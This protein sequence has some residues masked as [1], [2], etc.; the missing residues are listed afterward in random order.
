[1]Q[2]WGDIVRDYPDLV[3]ELPRDIVALEWGYEAEHPFDK[4][5]A[6]FANSKIPFYVC[7]GTS[8]WNSVAG[9][10]S[11]ALANLANAAENGLKHDAIG[12]LNTDWG[13]AGHWQPL[14]VS[15]LGYAYGAAVSW[16]VDPNRDIDI[17]TA[18]NAFS[19][20]DQAGITGQA[21]YDLGNVYQSTEFQLPNRTVLFQVLQYDPDGFRLLVC[22]DGD[23]DQALKRFRATL[24]MID[25]SSS[26]MSHGRMQSSDA[27]LVQSEF[28]W[29]ADM[30]RH[31]CWRSIWSLQRTQ[32]KEDR[33]LSRK[34]QLDAG[35]LLAQHEVIW[36]ARNR[37]GGF[38]DS[39]AR[40]QKMANAYH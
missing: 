34:L 18:L 25:D 21:A 8:S 38:N 31:S 35:S 11:N 10:T 3:D 1:M 32:G 28:S 14:P 9:R 15:Y 22:P 12:Y 13:D 33:T 2:F 40:L 20:L 24:D 6:L 7:P 5:G 17:Q 30:L 19:F 27:E 16:A 4:N 26:T 36:H 37:P 39:Q 23:I 29:V